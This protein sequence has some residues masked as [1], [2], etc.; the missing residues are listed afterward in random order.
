MYP[1]YKSSSID[2]RIRPFFNS[3][4]PAIGGKK[5]LCSSEPCFHNYQY[6]KFP[7]GAG[8]FVDNNFYNNYPTKFPIKK[9]DVNNNSLDVNN[10]SLLDDYFKIVM[11]ID[12]SGSM[13]EIKDK[14]LK[15]INDLISEQ[16]QVKERPATFTLVKFNNVI[17]RVVKNK[18]LSDITLLKTTDYVPSG[19]TALYDAIGDT[20]EW[21][22]NEKDV[23]MVIITDGMN[24]ASKNYTKNQITSMIE[25]KKRDNNWSYVYLSCDLSTESQGND[26]GLKNSSFSANC[27]ISQGAYGDFIGNKLNSAIS[28]FR[29]KGISVQ[30]QLNGQY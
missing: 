7:Y 6:N 5:C 30:Q 16:K 15:S 29:T 1:P 23:L 18:N 19:T 11:V 20:I 14:M 25:Q 27:N 9:P 8:K 13:Q 21:F 28:N 2:D 3:Q 17:N 24:N 12:E 26:M 10:N 4:V 22:K